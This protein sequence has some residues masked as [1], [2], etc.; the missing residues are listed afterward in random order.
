M[1]DAAARQLAFH[2]AIVLL[3]GLACGAPYARAINRDAE[4][5]VIQS[6]RVAHA[7]LP[8]GATLMFAIAALL[9]SFQVTAGVRWFIAAS[10]I[11][12]SYAFC[13]SLPLAALVGHRGLSIGGPA[14]AK[15]VF[16]LNMVG[17]WASIAA[18]LALVYAAFV[19]L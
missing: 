1:V 5:K 4:A 9:S 12:S 13:V 15:F 11:V 6:W 18:A 2:G 7:A 14:S 8:I 17:A 16:V 3:V 19:S 10:L